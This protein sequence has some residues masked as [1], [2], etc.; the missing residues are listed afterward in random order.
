MTLSVGLVGFGLAARML[1]APLILSSGMQIVG[2]VSRQD[3]AVRQ[4][5]PSARV[6]PDLAS[7]LEMDPLDL[8]VIATPNDLHVQQALLSL[9]SGKHTLV[10]KPLAL[11]TAEADRLIAAEEA[12][13]RKLAVF[14]NRRWDS[15]FLTLR[16][17]VDDGS[18]G[19][20]MS[21]EARWDRF[22][23]AVQNR[24][25]ETA[26]AGGGV[27]YDL[28]S[29]LIDQALCI[30]GMPD[31][32]DADVYTQRAGA[33]VD[34]SFEIRMGKGALRISLAA[35]SLA[36][37]HAFRYRLHGQSGSYT[38]SGMDVQE[39]QL[40]AGMSPTDADFGIEPP[41]QW[42]YCVRAGEQGATPVISERG[43]WLQFYRQ[44]R[45]SIASGSAAPVTAREARDV[46]AV[47]E[48]AR[49]SS[50]EG[51][52]VHFRA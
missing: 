28:G 17:L 50:D 2:V 8:V 42:G 47:I 19:G 41:D 3:A 27:L 25:R 4:S 38:K 22:R 7:L 11:S 20:I 51:R 16:R 35:N 24:W 14:Q 15:D 52:R 33:L 40:R 43:N 5:L 12:A 10:E 46:L 1:H 44:L 37:D 18:L 21:F 13:Q 26:S 30:F 9:R 31:W 32:L 29:H 34:D 36:A 49:R 23:P 48:A 6:V 39:E 45:S